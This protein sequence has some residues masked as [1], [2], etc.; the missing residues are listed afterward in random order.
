MVAVLMLNLLVGLFTSGDPLG[1]SGGNTGLSI[2]FTA[3][4]DRLRRADLRP[5][6]RP[7]RRAWSPRAC[8]SRSPGG[9]AFGLVVGLVFLYLNIL[10]LLSY[11]QGSD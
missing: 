6:L 7:G 11:L 8:R 4:P 9:S 3:R 1:I 2:L 10:R 5:G